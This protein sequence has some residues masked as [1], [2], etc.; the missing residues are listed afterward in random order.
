MSTDVSGGGILEMEAAVC[1]L[2]TL[3]TTWQTAARRRDSTSQYRSPLDILRNGKGKDRPRTG[4]EGPEGIRDIA[5]LF[6]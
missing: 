2:V 5:L 3:V 4:H 1:L 6:L